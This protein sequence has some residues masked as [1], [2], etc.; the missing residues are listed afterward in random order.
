M[1]RGR[2]FQPGNQFGRGRPAGSRNRKPL[3]VQGLLDS[4]AEAVVRQALA[5]ARKGDPQ[6][7]RILLP[8]VLPRRS[9]AP[10]KTGP[11]PMGT[12]AELAQSSEKVL[13]KVTSGQITV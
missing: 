7:V 3:L 5:L 6:M 10:I 11:L 12:A 2:P 1:P 13:K 8:Y 4:E 9:E